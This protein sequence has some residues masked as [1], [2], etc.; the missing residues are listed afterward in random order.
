MLNRLA[1]MAQGGISKAT[2]GLNL[3]EDLLDPCRP[4]GVVERSRDDE[5]LQG[6]LDPL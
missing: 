4:L 1:L 6:G 5:P 2:K 3:S